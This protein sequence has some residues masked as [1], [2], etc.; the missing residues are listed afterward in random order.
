MDGAVHRKV[1]I[2][3]TSCFLPYFQYITCSTRQAEKKGR[4]EGRKEGKEGKEE[5]KGRKEEHR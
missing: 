1:G 4:K 3:M 5:R 2:D